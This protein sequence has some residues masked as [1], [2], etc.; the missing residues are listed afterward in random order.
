MVDSNTLLFENK[1]LELSLDESNNIIVAHWKGFLKLEVVQEGCQKL[2]QLVKSH[3]ISKHLSDQRE[4]KVLSKEVQSYL[5][6]D[7]FPALEA[8]GLRKLAVLSSTDVFAQATASKVSTNATQLG[9]ISLNTFN[10][11]PDCIAWLNS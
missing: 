7:V 11:K 10:A 3:N 8:A 1:S 9:N 2:I 5:V 4:L 6:S